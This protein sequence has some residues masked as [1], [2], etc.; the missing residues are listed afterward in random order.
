MK[1]GLQD[2]GVIMT[3]PGF[4]DEGPL[5]GINLGWDF[6]AEHEW[7]IDG[8]RAAFGI[9]GASKERAGVDAR[10]VTVVPKGLR[11]IGDVGGYAYLAFHDFIFDDLETDKE[12]A[13]FIDHA[14]RVSKYDNV[15]LMTG[16]SE[17]SFA[18]RLKGGAEMLGA[19][20]NA[21]TA[22]DAVILRNGRGNPFANAGLVIAIRSRF[23]Q[24]WADTLREA[25]LERLRLEEA[26]QKVYRKTSLLHI[27]E[28]AEKR[29]FALSSR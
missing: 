27:L 6:A 25:D 23:P 21:L 20:F 16:W 13:D 28:K 1:R 4:S 5:I 19:I 26:T 22:K 15:D 3:F 14:L 2:T 17:N 7:G 29:F 18:I 10:L 24:N 9:T 12:A 8:I 11:F